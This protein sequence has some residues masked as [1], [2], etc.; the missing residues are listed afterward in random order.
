MH[1]RTRRAILETIRRS[2]KREV[3]REVKRLRLCVVNEVTKTEPHIE[4]LNG[5]TE[6]SPHSIW[7]A[8]ENEL[9]DNDV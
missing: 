3:R 2:V 1:D 8:D 9:C 6:P 7:A 4:N 5:P